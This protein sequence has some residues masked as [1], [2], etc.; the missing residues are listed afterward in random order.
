MSVS[1]YREFDGGYASSDS[2]A[3]IISARRA[4]DLGKAELRLFFAQL[5][6]IES[7]KR[8]PVDV[9][10]NKARKQ[11]KR[12]TSG[13]QER[14][15][16]R[17][18]E[19]VGEHKGAGDYHVK[20]PRKFVRAAARGALEVSEIITALC[21]FMRRMPQRSKRKC[22]V[23]G[24]RYGRLSVRTARDLTGLCVAV[25]V[26]A[27]RKLRETGLIALIWRPMQEVKRYGRLFVD[28]VKVSI[29]YHKPER[30]RAS[31]PSSRLQNTRTVP[32]KEQNKKKV[33]LP[34]NSF[35]SSLDEKRGPRNAI[36]A[37]AAKFCLNR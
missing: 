1:N 7:G 36:A 23:K 2:V 16:G 18:R 10:L 8:A 22:L 32:A 29:S 3:A 30:S 34:K 5:E 4:G 26:K 21:Y 25:I 37:F 33:T 14:A 24:E 17:L 35:K 31:A 6:H 15:R 19:A 20:L 28:G 13:Q 27:L 9:I 12:M 11:K